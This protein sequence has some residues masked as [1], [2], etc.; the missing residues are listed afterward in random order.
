MQEGDDDRIKI[1][2]VQGDTI[3]IEVNNLFWGF[4]YRVPANGL[5]TFD[6]INT[7]GDLTNVHIGHAV[8]NLALA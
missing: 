1:T 3:F 8:A 7:N 4:A 2:N 6:F 5:H